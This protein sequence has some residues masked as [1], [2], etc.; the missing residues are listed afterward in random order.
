MFK[1][2]AFLIIMRYTVFFICFFMVACSQ[3]KLSL[4]SRLSGATEVRHLL[5]A[6]E[7]FSL[8][9][10]EHI[11]SGEH[12]L[13]FIEGDGRPWV[14][15]GRQIS[16]DPTPYKTPV[17]YQFL[18]AEMTGFQGSRLYLGRPC[19]FGAGP[20]ELCHPALWSFSR[21]SEKVVNAMSEG[22]KSWLSQNTHIRY[23]TLIGH[24]GGGVLAMLIAEKVSSVRQVVTYA[25]PFDIDL[26]SQHHGHTPLF[27]SLN[28]AEL[29]VW[30]DNVRRTLVFGEDDD[31]VPAELFV[32]L[33]SQIPDV[34]WKIHPKATHSL[35][36]HFP[37]YWLS[38]Q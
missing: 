24:S 10:A 34:V 8:S 35:P 22:L 14:S 6:G 3:S 25:A 5:L 7:G 29:N 1:Q 28:P 36:Q 27:D 20:E 33:L 17:L 12:A 16:D 15:G 4:E 13:V 30:R 11:E 26:W 2:C 18:R 21:Y 23:V 31:E 19:Y 37:W 9:S 38:A 32:G